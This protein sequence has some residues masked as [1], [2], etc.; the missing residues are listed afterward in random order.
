MGDEKGRILCVDDHPDICWLIILVLTS[1]GYKV[2]SVQSYTEAL[3]QALI[4]QYNLYII[5]GDL[6]GRMCVDLYQQIR[7][8][9]SIVP[10]LFTSAQVLPNEIS[11][12]LKCSG[13]YYLAYP[14]EIPQLEA[15]V[16]QLLG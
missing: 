12:A 9:N 1:L 13:N 4:G 16:S 7:A 14:F 5:N 2:E 3:A 10:I 11:E 6:P 8:L 15:L